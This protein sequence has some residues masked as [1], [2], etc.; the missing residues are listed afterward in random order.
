MISNLN[1]SI[2]SN[3][4]SD[5]ST[6]ES[7]NVGIPPVSSLLMTSKTQSP[8]PPPLPPKPP[9]SQAPNKFG[10]T[11]K[12]IEMQQNLDDNN[13]SEFYENVDSSEKSDNHH[14]CNIKDNYNI[15]TKKIHQVPNDKKCVVYDVLKDKSQIYTNKPNDIFIG[16]DHAYSQPFVPVEVSTAGGVVAHSPTDDDVADDD[17]NVDGGGGVGDNDGQSLNDTGSDKMTPDHHAR[18]PMNA[19]LIFCKR[20]R[21]IVREKY[22]NLE[23][24]SITKI[25]GDWWANLDQ[26]EKSCYTDLA[27]QYKDAFFTANPNFKWYKLPAPPLRT[28]L[29]RP[30]NDRQLII[31]CSPTKYYGMEYDDNDDDEFGGNHHHRHHRVHEQLNYFTSDE[32][33]GGGIEILKTASMIVAAA[34]TTKAPAHT[35][36]GVFKLADETQMGGLNSLMQITNN[37]VG[38]NESAFTSYETEIKIEETEVDS[39]KDSNKTPNSEPFTNMR[40]HAAKMQLSSLSTKL[41]IKTELNSGKR[42]LFADSTPNN[43]P[44]KK[45]FIE[46]TT[47]SSPIKLESSDTIMPQEIIE[48]EY[49]DHSNGDL[50]KKSSRACKGKRYQE[51]M[52][53]GKIQQS[54]KKTKVKTPTTPAN[55][56]HNGYCKTYEFLPIQNENEQFHQRTSASFPHDNERGAILGSSPIDGDATGK[57]YDASDFHLE[58]KIKALPSL[59][60]EI[61]LA[62]KRETKKKKRGG[63]KNKSLKVP[64][65]ILEAQD[66]YKDSVVGSRKRKAR[67]ESITRRDVTTEKCVLIP[68]EEMESSAGTQSCSN[69]NNNSNGTSDLLILATLAEALESGGGGSSSVTSNTIHITTI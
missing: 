63:N 9:S 52:T 47:A 59:N 21:S 44:V 29:T 26:D 33:C 35:T 60:L 15:T 13:R 69:N 23:N 1:I 50:N 36:V 34:E 19:F 67:K 41:H 4:D 30:S 49:I 64:K 20:H 40:D 14:A 54:P 46:T 6:N 61:F 56:P 42:K 32:H 65:H 55:F 8:T 66:Y 27:K 53:T 38:E 5:L 16:N 2:Q 43:L 10:G 57:L 11:L 22:P 58:E 3:L 45:L 25:L 31:D 24:R 51:F 48:Y 37:N 68:K 62:K 28:L 12:I 18:R 7:V 39:Q 17:E